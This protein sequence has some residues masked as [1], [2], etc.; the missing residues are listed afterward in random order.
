MIRTRSLALGLGLAAVVVALDQ[1]TKARMMGLLLDPPRMIGLTDFFDLVPVWN[2]GVSFGILSSR[3]GT[4]A[5][6]LGGVALLVAAG[7]VVWLSRIERPL[8][9][10]SLGLVI[11]GAL[12]NV[13]DRGRFGAV[14]D[15]LDFHVARWHF[16]AFNLADSAITIGVALLLLDG[17]LG[18]RVR[19]AETP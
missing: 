2:R 16:P 10:L 4:T 14:F 11:G 8:L 13:V 15:F 7:L 9:A 1:A 3:D 6:L 12:G 5:W 17:L 18:G 19:E